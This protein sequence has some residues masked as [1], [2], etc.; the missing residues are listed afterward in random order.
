MDK[1]KFSEVL[2]GMIV[3]DNAAYWG[4]YYVSANAPHARG[5]RIVLINEDGDDHVA[6]V[7]PGD[8]DEDNE[9]EVLTEDGHPN[10][11]ASYA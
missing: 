6:Y 7:A 2:S 11:V 1:I 3:I 4:P 5:R 9:V 10:D 8:P